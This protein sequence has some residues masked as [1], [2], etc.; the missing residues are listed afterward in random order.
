LNK[1][2][3]YIDFTAKYLTFAPVPA[4]L[5]QAKIMEA[6]LSPQKMF[7]YPGLRQRRARGVVPPLF[8]G[9]SPAKRGATLEKF[10]IIR[11]PLQR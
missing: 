2:L 7:L 4:V 3:L 10:N 8:R 5:A 9:E 6:A 11:H 1:N